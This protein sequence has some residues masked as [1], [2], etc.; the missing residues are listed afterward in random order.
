MRSLE[1]DL[2]V[3][4]IGFWSRRL[5]DILKAIE[6]DARWRDNFSSYALKLAEVEKALRRIRNN[7]TEKS[8]KY[9]V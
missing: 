6:I 4:E 2:A 5:E 9:F 7:Y 1:E 3:G 8:D